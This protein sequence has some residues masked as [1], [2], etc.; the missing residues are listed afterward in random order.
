MDFSKVE[1]AIQELENLAKLQQLNF[2]VE[3]PDDKSVQELLDENNSQ[4]E[5]LVREQTKLSQC[6]ATAASMFSKA[7]FV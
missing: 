3:L 5:Q 2:L 1:D 6:T 7:K 4:L